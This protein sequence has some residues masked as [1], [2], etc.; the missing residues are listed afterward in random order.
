MVQIIKTPDTY[1]C[2]ICGEVYEQMWQ[3]ELC[4]AQPVNDSNYT[5]GQR[6][7]VKTLYD[8]VATV[9]IVGFKVLSNYS[10][11]LHMGSLSTKVARESLFN[12]LRAE[13]KNHHEVSFKISQPLQMGK[14]YHTI[15]DLVC[16]EDIV[17]T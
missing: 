14:D 12:R 11:S 4:E 1:Q 9:T 10:H 13:G 5:L 17:E 7:S 3:A 2:Q 15:T 8:G 16:V 6:I